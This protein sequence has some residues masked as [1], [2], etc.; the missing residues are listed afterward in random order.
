MMIHVST[1]PVCV[2][3]G[4]IGARCN[5]QSLRIEAPIVERLVR[6]VTIKSEAALEAATKL[7][8]MFEP[9][10]MSREVV[11]VLKT[12]SNS[13]PLERQVGQR[14]RRLTNRKAWM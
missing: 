12:V 6:M 9:P 3:D 5:E 1:Q 8:E 13:N 14:R 7:G 4:I 11:A 10:P 2:R